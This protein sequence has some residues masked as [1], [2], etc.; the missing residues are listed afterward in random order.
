M[1]AKRVNEA[2]DFERGQDPKKSM[3]IGINDYEDYVRIQLQKKYPEE[4]IQDIEIRYWEFFYD[5]FEDEKGY[6][7]AE[8]MMD[9][10]KHTPL[11]Y[12]IEWIKGNLDMF[13]EMN[14]EDEG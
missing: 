4:D 12:Q 6:D 13:F 11:E 8:T 3:G 7:V 2:Q 10:L 9:I 14:D 5:G 1:R